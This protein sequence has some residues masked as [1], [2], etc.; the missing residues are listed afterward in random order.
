MKNHAHRASR[1]YWE[2]SGRQMKNHAGRA[3]RAYWGTSGT[4]AETSR[5]QMLKSRGQS[6]Q[7]LVGDRWE[8]S[9]PSANVKS[10]GQSIQSVPGDRRK[11][12]DKRR[13]MGHT[14]KI[15]HAEHPERTGKQ[16]GDKCKIMRANH[17]ERAGRQVGDKRRQ[18]GD[19]CKIMRAEH[20]ERTGRQVGDKCKIMRPSWRKMRSSSPKVRI[21][22]SLTLQMGHRR[23]ALTF[24]IYNKIW[25][26]KGEKLK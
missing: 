2:T 19:T 22:G 8:A 23:D 6:I 9:G 4:Q 5:R 26:G 1:A 17:P 15:I 18:V 11:V 7:S 12:G 25:A 16:V 21:E 13:Q 20:P 14:C 10:R 24:T 3:S